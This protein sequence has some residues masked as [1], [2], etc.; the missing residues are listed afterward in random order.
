MI[1][2]SNQTIKDDLAEAGVI[3]TL[4]CHPE[5][6]F[7]GTDLKP[8]YFYN[9][10]NSCMFWAISELYKQ[11][12]DNIDAFNITNM[13][14][15]NKAVSRI[16]ERNNITDI[17]EYIT[18]C[19][20]SAR[21]TLEEY[22]I[23]AG[24]VKELAFK[25]EYLK[26]LTELEADCGKDTDLS[27]LSS[28]TY[29]RLS[30]LTEEF[31]ADESIEDFGCQVDS[32][33]SE[34]VGRRSENGLFGI[35]SKFE[36]LN[37]YITYEPTELILLKAR[38]KKGKSA[39][40]MN[41]AIH[42]IKMGVPTVYF[43]TEMSDRLFLERMISNI[44]GVQLKNLKSGA[45]TEKDA[46]KIEEAKE[47]IKTRPF[48]HIYDPQFTNEK[49]YAACNILQHKIG[50]QFV[51]F[52]YMK[53]NTLDSSSQYNELGGKCDFLKNNI[54]GD[55]DLSVLAACQLNRNNEVA[56]SDKIERYC[57]ASLLWRDKSA[58]EIA[59]DGS[60]CGNYRLS[61]TLNR[62]GEQMG[63]KEYI[64][65]VFDGSRMRINQSECQHKTEVSNF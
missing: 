60:E 6:I 47:W 1:I 48:V 29:S 59:L 20:K 54:A 12:V 51:I 33:W 53:S 61:V 16:M 57:S 43:D 44:S 9:M 50:L 7:Q 19:S 17:N 3:S 24:R 15:S 11:G 49:I 32:L 36:L 45:Y 30:K 26:M 56:D 34:I 4:V 63:D 39:W 10:D 5:F 46:A 22:S 8:R 52:D 27:A 18:L 35:P 23:L 64:D 13:L 37:N 25:R 42:K 31:V 2:I 58:D 41:E 55:L 40:M 28:N 21:N 62:L 14:N 38:M 65:F